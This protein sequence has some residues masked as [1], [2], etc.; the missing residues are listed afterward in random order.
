MMV[1]MMDDGISWLDQDTTSLRYTT[2]LP[3][4]LYIS[5]IS[6]LLPLSLA[7]HA[8]LCP[9]GRKKPG[10]QG[11]WTRGSFASKQSMKGVLLISR[12]LDFFQL[13]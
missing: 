11:L 13:F 1:C 7:M 5:V 8:G 3:I 6:S 12:L 10:R 2:T 9:P 4:L